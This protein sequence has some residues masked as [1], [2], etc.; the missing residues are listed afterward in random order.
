MKKVFTK[1]SCL[2]LGVLLFSPQMKAQEVK[3]DFTDLLK[4][5][6]FEYWLGYEDFG[7]PDGTPMQFA[8]RTTEEDAIFINNALRETP[9]GWQESV[10][11][12]SNNSHGIN[13]DGI[14][15][16]GKN[17]FW[18]STNPMPD[19]YALYQDVEVGTGEGQ[20]PP[21]KYVISC[22]MSVYTG[23]LTNQR[24]FAQ[25]LK[26]GVVD[27]NIVQYI[28]TYTDYLY[29]LTEGETDTYADWEMGSAV[30]G[31]NTFL[32]PLSVTITVAAGETLR[33]GLK[34][35]DWK[36]DGSHVDTQEGFVKADDFR[37]TLADAPA[38]PNDYTN[39]I[40]NPSF[41][42]DRDGIPSKAHHL[43]YRCE[44]DKDE[45]GNELVDPETG[46]LIYSNPPYGWSHVVDGFKGISYGVNAEVNGLD[47]ARNCWAQCSPF[48]A[49]FELYQ[50]ITGLPAGK[51]QVSCKLW[52]GTESLTQQRLFAKTASQNNAQYYYNQDW[53]WLNLDPT[54]QATFAWH[55][56]TVS[57]REEGLQLKD[58]EVEIDVQAGEALRLGFK[59]GNLDPD[60]VVMTGSQGWFKLDDFRLKKLSDGDAID[61]TAYDKP[62]KSA[63]YYTLTG[64]A[65][66]ATAK[67][68]LLKK[69]TYTDGTVKVVKV[70]NK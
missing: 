38:D 59:S 41:E 9:P 29:N 45:A 37:I 49:Y 25:T 46:N 1:M 22:R 69:V 8:D 66:T 21:G 2:A 42:L 58:M 33:L 65:T 28:G 31:A 20:L 51:Y 68:L 55:D 64:V 48:P 24:L 26:D 67:G 14:C 19:D 56:P 60:G 50:V 6:S 12:F 40:T 13:R 27:Q 23:R 63:Q 52:V 16:D 39:K 36:A 17:L 44:P 18:I 4:N 57:L 11:D 15:K 61:R 5:P 62:E 34:T 3:T 35:G 53:Y 47:G 10:T 70:I 7:I 30:D 54:E 43:V 32:K